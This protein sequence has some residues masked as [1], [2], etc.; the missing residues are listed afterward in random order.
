[1]RITHIERLDVDIPYA[2]RVREHLHKGWGYANRAT[3]EEFESGREGFLR[4]W[5]ESELPSI[6]TSI[7]RVHTDE[8]LIGT[9]QGPAIAD[10][11]LSA[12]AG[13]S[14]F[15][16]LLDD[17]VGGLQIAFYD[18]MG[19]HVGE[20]LGHLFGPC[21]KR[22]PIAYWSQCFPPDVLRQEAEIALANGF[23]THKIKRRAHTDVVEQ[24]SSIADVAPDDYRLTI[25]ANQTFGSVERA[26]A[27]GG[28]LKSF[29]QVTC[30]ESPVDQRDV[31]GY[32]ALKHELGY[33]LAI[34]FGRPPP[35]EALHSEAYDYFV[36][37]GQAAAVIRQAHFLDI[38]SR[39]F[40][41]Q[42][43]AHDTDISSLFMTHLSAALPNATLSHVS[44][45]FLME[46]RVLKEP[47]VVEDGHMAVPQSPGL[48]IELDLDAV[49]RYRVG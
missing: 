39:P 6:R 45:Y 46:S 33:P 10:E 17:A 15:D 9:G 35:V 30:L 7:Y 44:L 34:H 13:T 4:E 31:E 25:D 47:L 16:Y 22:T 29:P 19:Q 21:R 32:R 24:V 26:R 28:E 2:E 48:G 36:L 40:W 42:L 20:P 5:R 8:G 43:G 1:M 37:G 3:D 11:I 23:T 12:Y 14:P 18:L 49:E 27:V 41:L 38:A